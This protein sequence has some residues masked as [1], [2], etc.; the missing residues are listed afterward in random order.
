MSQVDIIAQLQSLRHIKIMAI[1]ISLVYGAIFAVIGIIMPFWPIWLESKG[2]SP[3]EIG[4]ILAVGTWS[5][6]ILNP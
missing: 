6:A 2:I 1:R 4:L 3:I 5:R